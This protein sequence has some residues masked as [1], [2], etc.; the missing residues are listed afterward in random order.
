MS[1]A[2]SQYIQADK[3]RLG[4]E[5]RNLMKPTELALTFHVRIKVHNMFKPSKFA[6]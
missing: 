5:F 4:F 2:G 1:A 3:N 6:S